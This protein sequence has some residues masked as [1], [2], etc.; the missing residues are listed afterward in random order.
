M[1][2]PQPVSENEAHIADVRRCLQQLRITPAP[3][4]IRGLLD[5]H[6]HLAA[7]VQELE[8]A[9]LTEVGKAGDAEETV[10][11]LRSVIDSVRTVVENLRYAMSLGAPGAQ[12]IDG[13]W[14]LRELDRA[15]DSVGDSAQPAPLHDLDD[16]ITELGIEVG[17]TCGPHSPNAHLIAHDCPLHA[18]PTQNPPAVSDT[19]PQPT[20]TVAEL[21]REIAERDPEAHAQALARGY[22]INWTAPS[23][24]TQQD[25]Q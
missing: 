2:Q 14:I 20:K 9:L 17:C 1:T 15:L 18:G 25:T 10:R 24:P 7:R 11:L 4:S 21:L 13:R 3:S 5:A 23:A 8:S 12:P 16:V 22:G 19:P 6:D